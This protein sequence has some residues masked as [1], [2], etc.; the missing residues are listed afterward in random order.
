MPDN[1]G[2]VAGVDV[3]L[4]DL[5]TVACSDGTREK[6][7]TPRWLAREEHTLARAQRRPAHK[8]RGSKNG[9]K[10][11]HRVAVLD[12][13]YHAA[14]NTMVAAGLAETL[15]ACGGD[16]RRMLACADPAEAGTRRTDRDN[17][18]PAA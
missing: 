9:A 18:A 5:A 14:V 7:S 2:R 3:G 13:D 12:R 16:V 17:H 11:R 1:T 4:T 15:N 8:Q 6:I 10:A